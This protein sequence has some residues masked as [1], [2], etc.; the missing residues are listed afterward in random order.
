[1]TLSRYFVMFIST[2]VILGAP[3]WMPGHADAAVGAHITGLVQS[4]AG[5]EAGVWVI[6]E[7]N[8]L[9]TVFRKIVVTDNAGRFLLPDLPDATYDVWARGYG[10]LDS[11]GVQAAPGDAIRLTPTT[12]QTPQEAAKIYPANYWYSLLEVPPETDFPGTGEDGNGIARS[13]RSQAAWVDRLKDG[14]Q[15]CHQMGNVATRDIPNLDDFDSTVAAWEHRVQI[16]PSG[17]GMNGALTQMG[18][19]RALQLFAD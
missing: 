13:M 10:L 1:M 11:T 3:I 4:D 9:E 6:A 12:A 8:D 18:R 5:P 7:T 19:S 16:G 2:V 17:P 14:C 15:L